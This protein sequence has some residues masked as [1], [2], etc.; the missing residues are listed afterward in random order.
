M[1][2]NHKLK[3]VNGK[4]VPD[5]NCKVCRANIRFVEAITKPRITQEEYDK[6]IDEYR[7]MKS[8]IR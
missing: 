5:P 7:R 6:A 8:A 1:A 4:I 2:C 3:L